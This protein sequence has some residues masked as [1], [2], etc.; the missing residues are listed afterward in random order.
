MERILIVAG[1]IG[2][3][4][5]FHAKFGDTVYQRFERGF[6]L[7]IIAAFGLVGLILLYGKLMELR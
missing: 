7:L 2:A 4:S 6:W 1:V 5:F 3:I